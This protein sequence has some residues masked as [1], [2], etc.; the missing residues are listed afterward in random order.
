MCHNMW[1]L[2]EGLASAVAGVLPHGVVG[3]APLLPQAR[4]PPWTCHGQRNFIGLN[5]SEYAQC[6]NGYL[7]RK[8][9]YYSQ[10]TCDNPRHLMAGRAC[11]AEPAF[12]S[13][14]V[15]AV[16]HPFQETA[17]CQ[18]VFF[19]ETH[20]ECF[21][22]YY[23][24]TC[25]LRWF[26]DCTYSDVYTFCFFIQNCTESVEARRASLLHRRAGKWLLL[27][28]REYQEPR[29]FFAFAANQTSL[30]RSFSWRATTASS[31][32]DTCWSPR[33]A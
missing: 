9:G 13:L 23:G 16:F 20:C 31:R 7:L 15:A 19:E 10:V 22:F 33:A 28:V 3:V 18:G 26:H 27:L 1:S 32:W 21:T 2:R 17:E 5:A 30:Q 8:T 4:R 6:D 12:H 11:I 29:L 14:V 24:C 25:E